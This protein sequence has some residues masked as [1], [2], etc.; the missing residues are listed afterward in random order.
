MA[1]PTVTLVQDRLHAINQT[2]ASINAERHFVPAGALADA[3]LPLVFPLPRGNRNLR[4]GAREDYHTRT[5]HLVVVAWHFLASRPVVSA[6]AAAEAAIDELRDAYLARPNLFLAG[7]GDM[8]G[9]LSC[10]V[11]GDGGV[12]PLFYEPSFASVVIPLEI[13][14]NK[15]YQW[16]TV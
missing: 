11:G 5:Y 15:D 7:S 12:E 14:T 16:I 10:V 3:K 13:E 1:D 8:D 4:G 6:Q 9:V 2:L